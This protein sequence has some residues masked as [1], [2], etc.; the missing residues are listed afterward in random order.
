[1]ANGRNGNGKLTPTVRKAIIASVSRGCTDTEACAIAGIST[2]TLQGWAHKDG[3]EHRALFADLARAREQR[4]ETLLDTIRAAG[5]TDW[6]AAAWLLSKAK[7]AQF[8]D[9]HIVA[10]EG[11][12]NVKT[13]PVEVRIVTT[14]PGTTEASTP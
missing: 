6:R 4:I 8:S 1:M 11:G 12:L 3:P 13:E 14:D 2:R 9:K 5:T 7:P 10:H